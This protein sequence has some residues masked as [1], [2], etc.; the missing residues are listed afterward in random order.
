MGRKIEK[1]LQYMI[2]KI[3]RQRANINE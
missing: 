1:P 3:I 2:I